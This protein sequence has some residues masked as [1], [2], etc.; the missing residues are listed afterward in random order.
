MT[1][2]ADICERYRALLG[3]RDC[4]LVRAD[5]PRDVFGA[6]AG[7]EAGGAGLQYLGAIDEPGV[8]VADIRARARLARERGE[9]LVVE[10]SVPTAFGCNP[11]A[12]GAMFCF[13]RLCGGVSAISVVRSKAKRA[14]TDELAACAFELFQAVSP[15]AEPAPSEACALVAY[16]DALPIRMQRRFDHA[17]ALAEYFAANEHV[18]QVRYPG[19]ESHPDHRIAAATLLHGAGFVLEIDLLPQTDAQQLAMAFPEAE[20]A[21]TKTCV[22]LCSNNG[23]S[24]LRIWAGEDDPLSVIDRI[25][26]LLRA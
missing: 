26:P 15:L 24:S 22:L 20:D 16:L 10:N 17:R 1:C 12:C 13:E 21:H 9:L 18:A 4:V 3:A 5:D 19:L 23:A 25:D 6:A 8:R 2:A 11:L 7:S 14:R